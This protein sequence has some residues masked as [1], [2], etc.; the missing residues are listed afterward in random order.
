MPALSTK[1]PVDCWEMG[2]SPDGDEYALGAGDVDVT[3]IGGYP[4]RRVIIAVGSG[5]LRV[6]TANSGATYRTYSNL[7]AGDEIGPLQ[8]LSIGGTSAGSTSGI[9]V[10]VFK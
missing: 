2:A 5:T 3:A 8:I 6:K 4:V 1:I 7:I 10:R 9:T